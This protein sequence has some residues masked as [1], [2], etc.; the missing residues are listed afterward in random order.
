M[1]EYSTPTLTPA[2]TSKVTG[3]NGSSAGNFLVSDILDIIRNTFGQANGVA[4]LDGSG[5][6]P[7]AQLPDI[8]DDV[9]VYASKALLPA[10]G[11]EAKIYI[12]TDDNVLYRWD[13]TLGDYVQLS[14]D[15]SDYATL[16]DLAAEESARETA[17]TNLND[18]LSATN[19]R[20]ENLEEAH[21][22]YHEVDVKSVYTIPSGKAKN[23]IVDGL[24]GVSRVEN[25]LMPDAKQSGSRSFSAS[26]SDYNQIMESFSTDEVKVM[27]GHTYLA[28]VKITRTIS[29]NNAIA[30]VGFCS[31]GSN[32]R[33]PLD[34]G[35][36]NGV[37]SV[38]YSPSSS[39][40]LT[41]LALNN[42]YGKQGFDSGDSI[43]YSDYILT[44]LS[45]YFG[46]TIP[47]DSDTIAKIQTN[48]PELLIPS[49]Y[50]TGTRVDTTYSAVKSVEVNIWDEASEV[51]KIDITNGQTSSGS[52][53]IRSKNYI[54][55][56]GNTAYY[57]HTPFSNGIVI[58]YY[59]INKNYLGYEVGVVNTSKTTPTNCAYLKF[60]TYQTYGET[61]NHDI[62]ICLNSYTDKTTYHPY[63]T[64]TL[65][66]PEPV[67]G[68]SAG[69]VHQ[70]YYPE[71]GEMTEPL[72]TKNLG[73]QDIV[74]NWND[75]GDGA[76]S[77]T[78]FN[79]VI[80]KP[81]SNITV[82]DILCP[83]YVA[84]NNEETYAHTKIGISVAVSGKVRI[85]DPSLDSSSNLHTLLAD[86][87]FTYALAT[88]NPNSQATDPVIADMIE[89]EGGGSIEAVQ[90]QETKIDSSFTIGYMNI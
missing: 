33:L 34:N 2:G 72:G 40:Y 62:Q 36:A 66:L 69:S 46:G 22:S 68:K 5:K 25:N 12:T 21:G 67:T 43:A 79:S 45:V 41:D 49:D 59:D 37:V 14:V 30:L 19:K 64:H 8:A 60:Y 78:Y 18:A 76:W 88:P 80:K 52:G 57:F 35:S 55:V 70:I 39:G 27:A 47:S 9:L 44:D 15:L 24:R 11:V 85:Y 54:P 89:T 86:V 32:I 65:T 20:V 31:N 48:Y 28:S 53:Q 7:T 50:D 74:W 87:P 75:G 77:T 73:D 83:K 3:M 42:Y 13:A 84:A 6:L 29:Q 51:G 1:P 63:K 81:S 4:T 23:W 71:T 90:T 38:L 61:Y 10:Q 26:T 82:G 16:D 17:D 56:L 58:A